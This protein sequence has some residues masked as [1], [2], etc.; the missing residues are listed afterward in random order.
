MHTSEHYLCRCFAREL[1]ISPMSYL[2]R[3]RLEI[4]AHFLLESDLSVT[5]IAAR[6]GIDDPSY[7]A[8]RFRAAHGMTPSKYRSTLSGVMHAKLP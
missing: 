8:R 4:V 2:D 1:G 7:L 5:A 6:V 3:Y